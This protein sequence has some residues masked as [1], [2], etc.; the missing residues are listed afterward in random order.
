[1]SKSL[2]DGKTLEPKIRLLTMTIQGD[3]KWHEDQE[4]QAPDF[5]GEMIR[6][7]KQFYPLNLHTQTLGK[8]ILI[9]LIIPVK[10]FSFN[11]NA[12]KFTI[13]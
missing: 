8:F 10:S 5:S 13:T 2:L 3:R 11:F 6:V 4:K 9:D 1:M 7:K 12:L